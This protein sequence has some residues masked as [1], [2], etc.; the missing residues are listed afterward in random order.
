MSYVFKSYDD[1]GYYRLIP[2]YGVRL[3]EPKEEG[4]ENFNTCWDGALSPDGVFYYTLSSEAGKCDHAKLMR[5]DYENNCAVD[6][7]YMGDYAMARTRQLPHSKFHT[8]INFRPKEGGCGYTV[9]AVTH[10]T[11]RAPQHKEWMP[12]AHQ[13]DIWEGFPGGQI[14]EYDPDTGKAETW[15]TPVPRESIYGAKYDPKHD[16]LYMIGFIRGHVY[17]L[18]CKKR[19]VK[20]LGK[21]AEVFNYRLAL[22]GDGNIYSCTKSGEYYRINTELDC[23][24]DLHRQVPTYPGA[25]SCNTHYRYL[26]CARTH[27]SGKFMYL[28]NS[29][30]REMFQYEF[31]TGEFTTVGRMVPGDGHFPQDWGGVGYSCGTFCVD[32]YG[33]IWFEQRMRIQN[34]TSDIRMAPYVSRILRWDV[35][36]G[37]S[38][39]YIGVMG[40]PQRVHGITV[41]MEYDAVHDRI[42]CVDHG[43][44]FGHAGPSVIAIDLPEFRP[45]VGEPG[46]QT[47]CPRMMPRKLTQEE[48]DR[49]QARRKI[50]AGEQVTEKNV[51]VAFPNKDAYPVRLWNHVLRPEDS[52][53]IGL[54]WDDKGILHVVTGEHHR[55]TEYGETDTC[56]DAAKYVFRIRGLEIS[57]AADW[58][59]LTDNFI[60]GRADWA[61]LKD[62]YKAWLAANMLPQ[63]P[64]EYKGLPEVTGRRYRA[65]ATADAEWNGGRRLVGTRDAL[66]AVVDGE[67]VFALGNGAVYGPVRCLCTNAEKTLAWGVAGDDEDMGYIFTYDDKRGLRQ[68]G[69][70]NYDSLGFYR[71]SASN[72]LSSIALSPDESRLAIGGA[73]RLGTVH[74]IDL[75]KE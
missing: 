25:Y 43:T 55:F 69:M 63:K 20:D 14:L 5:Y 75:H 23:L 71:P 34:S 17:S 13:A 12:F 64:A 52:E 40:T 46:P 62:N 51:F 28:T 49:E 74:V 37:K 9:L 33:V 57:S 36:N 22:A 16:R 54:A 39:E 58:T 6:C 59:T 24:E 30:A 65:Y 10:N 7:A 73:D 42:Y 67:D 48:L 53:V 47:D 18:D 44:G 21:A 8:S 26:T 35:E 45:H 4:N 72:V 66:V 1:P 27:P 41:E 56:L 50:G 19:R 29:P 32:K 38:P 31:A 3:A 60:S 61:A 68:L 2:Q 15:G 11:D 70:L